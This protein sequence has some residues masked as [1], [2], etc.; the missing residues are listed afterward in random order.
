MQMGAGPDAAGGGLSA[1]ALA[2]LAACGGLF[3]GGADGPLGQSLAGLTGGVAL[4]AALWRL[5]V[6]PPL[7]RG[8]LW[9]LAWA[10]AALAWLVVV[11]LVRSFQQGGETL[12]V[13]PDFFLPRFLGLLG[14]LCL[15]LAGLMIGRDRRLR[16][17]AELGLEALIVMHLLL[18]VALWNG[19]ATA[20]GDSPLEWDG[21]FAGLIG[22]ANVTAAICVAGGQLALARLLS[23]AGARGHRAALFHGAALLAMLWGLGL[24]GSRLPSLAMALGAAVQIGRFWLMR[25]RSFSGGRAAFWWGAVAVATAGLLLAGGATHRVENL[26]ADGYARAF[27]WKEFVGIGLRA[28]WTGF[29][30]GAFTTARLFYLGEGDGWPSGMVI[31]SPH[32]LLLQLWLTGGAPYAVALLFA[33]GGV[34]LSLV[35]CL[36]NAPDDGDQVGRIAAILALLFCAQADIV[37]DMPVGVGVFLLIVGLAWGRACRDGG[38]RP[39]SRAGSH[40]RGR[41]PMREQD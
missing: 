3:L 9:P 40:R 39:R 18:G 16:R 22:N 12:P 25:D 7:P 14:G 37:L 30:P 38:G 35:R 21:R 24:T 32:A 36:R 31:H 28:P 8:A 1:V 4:L 15:L 23:G 34:G 2:L 10:G 41:A 27:Y 13:T 5:P 17:W 6:A 26:G 19:G 11:A 20:V 29:G 33:G